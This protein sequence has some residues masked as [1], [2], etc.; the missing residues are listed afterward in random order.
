ML[1]E[2]YTPLSEIKMSSKL[3]DMEYTLGE[4]AIKE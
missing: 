1:G 4:V 2:K 3:Y